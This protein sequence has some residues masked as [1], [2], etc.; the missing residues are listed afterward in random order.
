[1][2][3]GGGGYFVDAK[4][5]CLWAFYDHRVRSIWVGSYLIIKLFI[6][7]TMNHVFCL[8]LPHVSGESPLA[9]VSDRFRISFTKHEAVVVDG[10]SGRVVTFGTVYRLDEYVCGWPSNCT[11]TGTISPST[12]IQAGDALLPIKNQNKRPFQTII[13]F[14]SKSFNHLIWKN[15]N[16]NKKVAISET[17]WFPLHHMRL[18]P[19]R[20]VSRCGLMSLSFFLK[21]ATATFFTLSEPDNVPRFVRKFYALRLWRQHSC[22]SHSVSPN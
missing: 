17:I 18:W 20:D 19:T 21:K 11:H 12:S 15:S 16:I 3:E 5:C 1:M 9:L 7:S 8:F 13:F 22:S 14:L 2:G 4:I 10:S 6:F